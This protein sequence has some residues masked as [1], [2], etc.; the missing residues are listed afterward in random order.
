MKKSKIAL[1]LL[2]AFYALS[3]LAAELAPGTYHGHSKH[4]DYSVY[5]REVPGR[6]GSF[7]ALIINDEKVGYA[8]LVDKF[9]SNKYG[10]VPLKAMDNNIIGALNHTPSLVLTVNED[11]NH[12]R[13]TIVP[14]N[15][16]NKLGFQTEMSFKLKDKKD[17]SEWVRHLQGSF[18]AKGDKRAATLTTQDNNFES[19]LAIKSGNAPGDYILREV[20]SGIHLVLRSSLTTTGIEVNEQ[21][22]KIAVFINKE[23][24]L[25][26]DQMILIDTTNG[27]L[28]YFKNR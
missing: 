28:E 25:C 26:R 12:D 5:V 20:R 24:S 18:A 7:L 6:T 3:S 21:T 8:Y 2:S 22:S 16:G 23:T 19:S 11:T 13:I 27:N 17:R 14:N 10:M 4:T 15:S 9:N 1:A